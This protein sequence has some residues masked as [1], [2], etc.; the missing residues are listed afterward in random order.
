M[1]GIKLIS[2][3][4][5]KYC[6]TYRNRLGKSRIK[7]SSFVGSGIIFPATIPKRMGYILKIKIFS[8]IL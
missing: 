6:G 7:L 5:I 2:K 4:S 3:R 1:T 8:I